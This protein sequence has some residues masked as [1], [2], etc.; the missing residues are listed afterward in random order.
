[1]NKP[2]DMVWPLWNRVC[3]GQLGFFTW[4]SLRGISS[5]KSK[6]WGVGECALPIRCEWTEHGY[7]CNECEYSA[8]S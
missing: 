4:V 2:V 7:Q 8:T 5:D 1:M 3:G 6:G